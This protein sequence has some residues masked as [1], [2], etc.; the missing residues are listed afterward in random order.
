MEADVKMGVT[1]TQKGNFNNLEKWLNKLMHAEYLNILSV[2][3]DM[4]VQAL[5][6]ATPVDTGLAANSWSYVITHDNSVTTLAWVNDDIEGGCNV[7][8]LIDRGHVSK[9]GSWV[10]GL[11][12]ID[13]ALEPVIKQMSE[14]LFKE[15]TTP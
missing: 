2:Y 1:F 7:A 5:K 10:P 3:G 9:S 15:V 11:Y 8:V 4:G 12:F 14:A 13:T 6:N